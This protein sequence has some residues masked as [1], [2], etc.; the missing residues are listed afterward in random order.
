MERF[1]EI[2]PKFSEEAK[3][4]R[5][6][7]ET[8]G[9]GHLD[10]HLDLMKV[11]DYKELIKAG[12]FDSENMCYALRHAQPD[13]T[14]PFKQNIY[15]LLG[16]LPVKFTDFPTKMMF[17]NSFGEYRHLFVNNT[18]DPSF[19][20]L[21]LYA[22]SA[23]YGDNNSD[24]ILK[25]ILNLKIIKRLFYC[26]AMRFVM[27]HNHIEQVIASIPI[28]VCTD[29]ELA[30]LL[31]L[32]SK[33]EKE[34]GHKL[35][36]TLITYLPSTDKTKIVYLLD[37]HF[38]F[39]LLSQLVTN[40]WLG[41]GDTSESGFVEFINLVKLL[42]LPRAEYLKIIF[43]WIR[44]FLFNKEDK[45]FFEAFRAIK[46]ADPNDKEFAI[47]KAFADFLNNN[48]ETNNLEAA[49]ITYKESNKY[50]IHSIELLL[51]LYIN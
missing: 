23:L 16:G 1:L 3:R 27:N 20:L 11:A 13:E 35:L 38:D 8:H 50:A 31:I 6:V 7:R 48:S 43:A 4:F 15:R 49:T 22:S 24:K 5:K 34:K 41:H 37:S 12:V 17:Y 10:A 45:R 30:C 25:L 47:Y 46:M 19:L 42:K 33:L 14:V 9:F 40:E 18:R 28:H 2:V 26:L 32:I 29:N 36:S 44:L 51:N 21:D 39:I